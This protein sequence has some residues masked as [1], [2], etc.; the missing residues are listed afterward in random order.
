MYNNSV[1]YNYSTL[2]LDEKANNKI[3]N[4]ILKIIFE[5][6]KNIY[7]KIITYFK[8]LNEKYTLDNIERYL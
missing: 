4:F 3:F 8:Y 1:H 7:L 6:L 5:T 2:F